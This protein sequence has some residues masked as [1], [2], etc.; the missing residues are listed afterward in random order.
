MELYLAML[1]GLGGML[2]WGLADFFAKKTLDKIDA[3]RTLLW[4]QI[5]GIFPIL[6][7]LVFN[8]GPVNLGGNIILFLFL[9]AAA[10]LSAYFLFYRGLQKGLVSILSP[11]FAA[12]GGVAVL[13]SVFI[14][15]ETVEPVRWLGVALAF[16]GIILISFKP[17]KSVKLTLR[18]ISKGLPEVLIGMIIFGFFF[19]CQARFLKYQGEG[20]IVSMILTRC[21]VVLIILASI[22]LTSFGKKTRVEIRVKEN[23]LWPWLMLIALF[24]VIA[25]L[26][27]AWGL[28][29][30]DITSVVVVLQGAFPLP[31]II[32]ARIFLK[33]KLAFNQVIGVAA[34]IG[35]LIILAI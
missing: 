32:L 3:A 17:L 22:Y 25:S 34:I 2:G 23:K 24:D 5:F 16:S 7:Y 30:T 4:M 20:W 26:S 33:E 29:F 9:L 8:W 35:G 10:D 12:Q 28:K 1:A 19:P 21:I 27:V 11:V 14:F 6:V 31:T 18:N 13:V 15:K